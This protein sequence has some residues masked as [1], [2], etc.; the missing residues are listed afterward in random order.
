MKLPP[1]PLLLALALPLTSQAAPPPPAGSPPA[2]RRALLVID[3]QNEYVTGDLPI[4]YPDVQVSLQNIGAAMDAARRAGIPVIVIQN[5]APPGSP[6]FARGSDG[7]QLHHIVASRARDHYAEKTLPDAFAG[8]DLAEYLAAQ[9]SDTLTVVGYM[10]HNCVDSTVKHALHAG[11]KVEFLQDASGSVPYRNRAGV[12]SAEQ[13]HR[14]F[15]VVMQ[16]RFAAVLDTSEWIDGLASGALPERDSI[17]RSNQ[18]A[19]GRPLD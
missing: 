16:S 11:F 3:V 14:A 1:L 19:R 2:P 17:Y 6:L 4:E 7:W 8:T 18:R 5:Y 9:G 15:S 12:Q 10:T 13:I